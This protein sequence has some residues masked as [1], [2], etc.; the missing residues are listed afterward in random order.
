[1]VREHVAALLGL[2][3]LD[4]TDISFHA[5]RGELLRELVRDVGVRVQ[6]SEGDELEEAD[7]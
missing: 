2:G 7:G 3:A 5:F 6:T 1:M 4:K